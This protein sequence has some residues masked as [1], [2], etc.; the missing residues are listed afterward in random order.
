MNKMFVK[1]FKTINRKFVNVKKVYFYFIKIKFWS[2]DVSFQLAKVK[3]GDHRP[4]ASRSYR[5][6][7]GIQILGPCIRVLGGGHGGNDDSFL[8]CHLHRLWLGH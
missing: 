3:R 2:S 1:V 8:L 7:T 5:G 6:D 4:R